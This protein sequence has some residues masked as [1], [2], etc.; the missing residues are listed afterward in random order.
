MTWSGSCWCW[1]ARALTGAPRRAP[2]LPPG[3]EPQGRPVGRGERTGELETDWLRCRWFAN[4]NL[5][6]WLKR[7]DHIDRINA[8]IADYC[9]AA[10]AHDHHRKTGA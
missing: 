5:H 2:E 10:L 4:G 6:L 7:E 8:L 9:G 3:G 1:R